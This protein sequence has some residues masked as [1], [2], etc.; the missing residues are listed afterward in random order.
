MLCVDTCTGSPTK[1]M[2][3]APSYQQSKASA[4]DLSRVLLKQQQQ[5][6]D[7]PWHFF[8]ASA[9][10]SRTRYCFRSHNL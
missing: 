6:C 3:L 9:V 7:I 10:C 2:P 4:Q 8:I 1:L 5:L